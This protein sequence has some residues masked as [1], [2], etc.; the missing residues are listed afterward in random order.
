[1]RGI[2]IGHKAADDL[3]LFEQI[4]AHRQI[5]FRYTWVDYDT[6]CPGRLKLVPP[7]EQLAC[8]K[9]DYAAMKDEMFFGKPPEFEDLIHA[10]R[11]F[12]ET[13]NREAGAESS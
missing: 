8:W 4:A 2:G 13:F 5:Y 1:M 11:E 10:A 3:E 12:R 9:S 6:L 7:D